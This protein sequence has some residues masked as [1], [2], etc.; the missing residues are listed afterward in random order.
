MIQKLPGLNGLRAIAASVVLIVHVYQLAG[1]SGDSRAYHLYEICDHLGKEMV[2]LF[3]VISGYIITYILLKE[4]K[5]TDTINLKNFY[6]K[7]ILRI[8]P[9]YFAIIIAVVLLVSLTHVYD[10]FGP[11]SPKGLLL[12]VTFLVILDPF[13]YGARFSVMPHYW[14]L[15]VEE[16]FYLIWPPILKILKGKWVFYFP[17]ILI[18]AMIVIRNLV[19]YLFSLNPSPRINN[20]LVFLNQLNFTSIAIGIIGAWLV[21]QKHSVLKFLY[22]K[23]LQVICWI[24]F[25]SLIVISFYIPYV[26]FY[27]PYVDY[28]VMGI[29]FLV[30]IINVTTNPKPLISL[31]NKVMDR[32]GII[33]YGLYM[34]HWPLIPVIILA[35]KKTG[36]WNFF[37]QTRQLPLVFLSYGLTYILASVSYKYFESFFSRLRPKQIFPDGRGGIAST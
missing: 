33:S 18:T 8:W 37:I 25:F 6:I 4:K 32:T 23:W 35:I 22:N 21:V 2:N 24:I 14:S 5:I 15:S 3:F 36:L 7:R 30:L 26:L 16:Q 20:F 13:V 31:E 27:I 1:I 19:A 34:Y 17:I 12:L 28:E 10:M 9:L 29:V 11:L